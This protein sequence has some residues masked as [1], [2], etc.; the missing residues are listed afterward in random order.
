M[1]EKIF[2]Y[3]LEI[4]DI[5]SF[6]LVS[7]ESLGSMGSEE[8]SLQKMFDNDEITITVP[9]HSKVYKEIKIENVWGGD[10]ERALTFK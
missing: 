2:V 4:P 5:G 1:A 10:S 7:S 3:G 9:S 8:E 6:L